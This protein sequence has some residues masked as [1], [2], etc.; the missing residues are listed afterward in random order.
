P[1]NV[2]PI[3]ESFGNAKTVLND[4]SSRL[5]KFLQVHLK[6]GFIVGTLISQY[7]L[8]KSRVVFQGCGERS[9]HVFY[10]LLAGLPTE[11][12]EKLYLQEPETYFYL[13]QGRT[14]KVSGKYDD[15]DFLVL[16][17]ALQMI[18]LSEDQ[19]TS[20]WA[21]L[22]GILQLGNICFTSFEKESF[23]PVV[24]PSETEIQIVAKLLH[25]SADLLHRAITHRVTETRYDQILTPLSVESAIDARDSIAKVLYSQLFDWLLLKINEWL[26]PLEMDSTVGIVDMH[27]FEDLGMNSLEQLCINFA[28]EHLQHFFHQIVVTQE[29]EEYTQEDLLWSPVSKMPS[30]LCLDL[31]AAKPHGILHILDEQTLLSQATD[32]TFLQKCHY[33]HAN[34]RWYVKPN[35][36]LPIFTVQHYAGPVT[37]QV[38][39]FLNKNH[40]QLRPEILD[41]F[42]QSHLKLVSSLFQN[43]R[44]QQINQRESHSRVQRLKHQASTLVSRFQQSLQDLITKLERSHVFFVQ[45]IKPN[46]KK[47]PNT[48]DTEYVACQLRHLGILE[49]VCIRKGGYPIRISFHHF[50]TRYGVLAGQGPSCL[51]KRDGCAAVLSQ[52]VGDISGLYQIGVTKVFLKEKARQ[53]L[54]R[55]RNQKLTWAI[56]TLQRNLRGLINRRQF[57]VFR[58]KITVI[59]A[60][61]RGHLARKR[62]QRLKKTLLQFGVAILVSGPLVHTMRHYKVI[63]LLTMREEDLI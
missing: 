8:E 59:Q 33:R 37:Y 54:E 17:K 57:Q 10:E 42:S 47:V 36:P 50:L 3:L 20:I 5:G 63:K 41:I 21:V 38:H 62:Y 25:V 1:S 9:F 34:N 26:A 44:E 58:Q 61:F 6:H 11:Q 53:M 55:Q 43:V 51:Q 35:L 31:V 13:N 15:Q 49:A 22:A 29:E 32:H 60:H 18:G 2:L 16:I 45:C 14:C 52:V 23:E 28:N 27:G 40:D 4:N 48:F 39:K 30:E 24:I 7:L 46:S 19:L 12:K 56:V